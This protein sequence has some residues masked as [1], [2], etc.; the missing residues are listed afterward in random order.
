MI[1]RASID[2]DYSVWNSNLVFGNCMLNIFSMNY[3]R[4]FK[5]RVDFCPFSFCWSSNRHMSSSWR[6][7]HSFKKYVIRQE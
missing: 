1:N 7:P 5:E 4:I 3:C 2:T 6:Q